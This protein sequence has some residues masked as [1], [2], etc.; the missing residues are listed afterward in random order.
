[1]LHGIHDEEQGMEALEL[2]CRGVE[3]VGESPDGAHQ[4]NW[5]TQGPETL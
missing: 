1:M 5:N 2:K 4:G 3:G